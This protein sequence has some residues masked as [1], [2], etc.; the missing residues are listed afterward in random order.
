MFSVQQSRP[1]WIFFIF[2]VL[3]SSCITTGSV[4]KEEETATQ[5]SD[6][7][8]LSASNTQSIDELKAENERVKGEIE[9][10]N[11]LLKQHEAALNAL[12][13]H[14][15]PA[16]APVAAEAA[17]AEAV[18]ASTATDD[19]LKDVDIDTK[20]K[21]ARKLHEEK[22]YEEAEK[23]YLSMVG[24]RSVWYDER[25]RF[26]LGTMYYENANYK[27]SVLT[28]QDF[29]DKYPKSR[30]VS[31]AIYTQAESFIQMDQ[32]KDAKVF[33]N[34]LISRFPKSKEAEKAKKRLKGL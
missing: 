30:N 33:L 19:E 5:I 21:T 27:Q 26:F 6:L 4:K 24:T 13:K 17:T 28:L 34:D 11:Y 3:F 20:Y 1:F 2:A 25:V 9:K 23:Y 10:L 7:Q 15:S 22:K 32:K 29:I 16:A 14:G 18:V 12:N 8:A 31:T